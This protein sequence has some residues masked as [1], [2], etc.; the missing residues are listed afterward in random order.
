MKY[1]FTSSSVVFSLAFSMHAATFDV[2]HDGKPISDAQICW[3]KVMR[4]SLAVRCCRRSETF[5]RDARVAG[6][7]VWK[8]IGGARRRCRDS[9]LRADLMSA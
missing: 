9:A 8:E 7:S 4:M 1:A 6:P 2:R 5:W 3:F